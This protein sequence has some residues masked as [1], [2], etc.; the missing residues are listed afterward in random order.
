MSG[1]EAAELVE[2]FV[3]LERAGAAG[4]AIFARRVEE[5]GV[6]QIGGFRDAV[7]WLARVAGETKGEALGLLKQLGH[8]MTFPD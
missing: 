5:T 1:E 8:S 2:V 4:K 7:D 6:H 3:E